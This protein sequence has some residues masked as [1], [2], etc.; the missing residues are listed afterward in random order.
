MAVASSVRAEHPY[1]VEG[2]AD[3]HTTAEEAIYIGTSS[4]SQLRVDLSVVRKTG[5]SLKVF[6]DAR[7]IVV[8]VEDVKIELPLTGTEDPYEVLLFPE[9]EAGRVTVN[10]TERRD[11]RGQ[12]LRGLLS[13]AT[14]FTIDLEEV[15][16]ATVELKSLSGTAEA[17]EENG[18]ER[19]SDGGV[20]AEV[21]RAVFQVRSRTGRREVFSTGTGFLVD[22]SGFAVTNL[23]VVEGASSA[24]AVFEGREDDPLSVELW[25]IEP[26]LD[27]ALIRLERSTGAEGEDKPNEEPEFSFLAVPDADPDAGT[28]V[29]AIGFPKGLGYTLTRGIVSGVRPFDRLPE[30]LQEATGFDQASVWVQTDA[31]V[32]SGN[33]GGPL[34]DRQGRA[35]GINT[36]QWQT[37]N[38]LYFALSSQH[39]RSMLS[40]RPE[41]PV[42]YDAIKDLPTADKSPQQA[43]PRVDVERRLPASSVT[44]AATLFR[45]AHAC[46]R[47]RGKG[48]RTVRRQVGTRSNGF[49][50]VPKYENASKSCSRCNGTGMLA[51]KA[52]QQLA[53][54]LAGIVARSHP[55]D[56]NLDD[57]HERV[58]SALRTVLMENSD[59]L[60]KLLNPEARRTLD[61]RDLGEPVVAIGEVVSDIAVEN[62]DE[63]LFLVQVEG[64]IILLTDFRIL[65]RVPGDTVIIGGLLAGEVESAE[66]TIPVIQHGFVVGER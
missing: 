36:W 41:A 12:W 51:G 48:S 56:P 66:V 57:A 54:R 13:D 11:L 43:F 53:T 21:K 46:K 58:E 25:A 9:E 55:E 15:T 5:L 64:Q 52:L 27:L 50:K 37:G 65:D 17:P 2:G 3:W 34:V 61:K 19:D 28:D 62:V 49:I 14:A 24:V 30:A 10:G 31:P 35:L 44:R 45:N 47:C 16:H 42:G 1:V 63:R 60:A 20:L 18:E 38:D 32:N 33:S 26:E 29:W 8:S 39:I 7:T 59:E 23:H 40:E 4:E 6:S 22:S